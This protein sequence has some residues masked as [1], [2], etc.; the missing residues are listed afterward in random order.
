MVNATQAS[1]GWAGGAARFLRRVWQDHQ[2]FLAIAAIFALARA[3]A[4]LYL[5]PG[6]N[7]VN[8]APDVWVYLDMLRLNYGGLAPYRDYWLEYPP[9]LPWLLQA[10]GAL[11]LKIP[12]WEIQ[13]FVPNLILRL[14]L[15]VFDVGNLAL[16]YASARRVWGPANGLLTA[17]VWALAFTPLVTFLGW[18]EPLALFFL[19]LAVYACVTDRA[20]VAGLAMGIGFC[21]KVF[22]AILI[23]L[24]FLCLPTWRKRL[25]AIGAT[26]AAILAVFVPLYLSSPAYVGAWFINLFGRGGWE[27]IWALL[28]GYARYGV[29]ASLT[30]RNDPA[31]ATA[32]PVVSQWP[33]VWITL[34]MAIGYL[35]VATR[36]ID[37]ARRETRVWFALF[38]LGVF[39]LVS[40]G[41]SPQW[42]TYLVALTIL[43]LP[44]RSGIPYVLALDGLMML[45]FPVAF[46]LYPGD[47]PVLVVVIVLRTVVTTL[48]TL[49]AA[50][51]IWPSPTRLTAWVSRW[52]MP[53]AVTGLVVTG[54]V[55][56]PE[57]WRRYYAAR[58]D[59]EPLKP[60][61]E[62]LAQDPQP[63]GVILTQPR[64]VERMAPFT[65]EDI[66][67]YLPNGQQTPWRDVASWMQ[68][69]LAKNDRFWFVY[70]A[71]G[72]LP[73]EIVLHD[74]VADQIET[75]G[76]PVTRSWYGT[77]QAGLFVKRLG[78]AVRAAG[79]DFVGGAELREIA[80]PAEGLADQ[81]AICIE[82]AWSTRA[83]LEHDY[84]VFVHLIDA[85]GQLVAQNDLAPAVGTTGWAVGEVVQTRHGLVLPAGTSAGQL[86]V[87]V[88]LYDPATGERLNTTTGSDAVR[89]TP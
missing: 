8:R 57:M 80:L 39:M 78:A 27:T 10:V 47:T 14:A 32:T 1:A 70:A 49:E 19:L 67:N 69:R 59:V 31:S 43:A 50:A 20:L 74:Q 56:A 71:D 34:I 48:I 2:V 52:A 63:P 28:D 30:V 13:A 36:R 51:R 7:V 37:W 84:T 9:I 38:S 58:F 3:L 81:R 61:I 85:Q 18:Y 40:K 66:L 88:G 46:I 29:V 33:G 23:P 77:I 86:T 16:M 35:G 41:Y 55:A 44:Y 89:I 53:I 6:G 11:S 83:Q 79:G 17:T 73:E 15:A 60:L 75:W 76:C 12:P 42:N 22:P 5:V 4:A 68:T 24:A 21:V 25:L 45:E 72:N 62:Q 87:A 65:G 54:V 64:M 26:G 82:L